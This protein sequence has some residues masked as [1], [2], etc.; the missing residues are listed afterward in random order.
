DELVFECRIEAV[1]GPIGK[2]KA[3]AHV[4]DEL[5]ARGTLTFAVER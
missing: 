4:G 5:A 1:R 2:G 3:T